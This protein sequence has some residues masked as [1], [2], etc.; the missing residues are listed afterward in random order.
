MILGICHKESPREGKGSR[1]KRVDHLLS[2]I[3][4]VSVVRERITGGV[5]LSI[6][7]QLIIF[8]ATF[9]LICGKII[10][11]TL[12]HLSSQMKLTAKSFFNCFYS[13]LSGRTFGSILD[14]ISI[15][16]FSISPGQRGADK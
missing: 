16:F 11:E 4:F 9:M 7:G 3:L 12:F 8:N 15:I 6:I 1:R 13:V 5:K 2:R 14:S 10:S